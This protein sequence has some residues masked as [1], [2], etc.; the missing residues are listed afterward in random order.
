MVVADAVVV[1]LVVA[2]LKMRTGTS[3][4]RVVAVVVA[5]SVALVTVVIVAAHITAD[6]GSGVGC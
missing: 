2:G 3:L 6:V 1:L 5:A 4:V